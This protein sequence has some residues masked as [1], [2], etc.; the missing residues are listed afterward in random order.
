MLSHLNAH[1]V[2]RLL[3]ENRKTIPKF[4][5]GKTLLTFKKCNC[6]K[7]YPIKLAELIEFSPYGVMLIF[8]DIFVLLMQ[9]KTTQK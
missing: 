2:N 7:F 4:L 3:R 9:L 8:F 1:V 6:S 5:S